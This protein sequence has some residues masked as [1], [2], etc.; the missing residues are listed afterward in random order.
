MLALVN[1]YHGFLKCVTHMLVPFVL[2][3]INMTKSKITDKGE[4]KLTNKSS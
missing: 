1:V 4:D 3:P 2:V